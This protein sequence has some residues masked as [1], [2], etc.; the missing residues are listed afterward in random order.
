MTELLSARRFNLESSTSKTRRGEFA[1]DAG[2][3]EARG[4]A[5]G[6]ERSMLDQSIDLGGC[7]GCAEPVVDIHDGH[8]AAARVQ[9]SQ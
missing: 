3:F 2:G 9:H 1:S 8:A 6:G 7:V 5:Q 4:S